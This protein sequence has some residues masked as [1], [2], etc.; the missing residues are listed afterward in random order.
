MPVLIAVN[1]NGIIYNDCNKLT[2]TMMPFRLTHGHELM[3]AS[4]AGVTMDTTRP[5]RKRTTQGHLEKG[6]GAR[7][8]DSGLRATA[9]E[10]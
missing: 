1:L 8:V 3:T 6:S 2:F 4:Q 7:N 10:R 5:Q 9:G